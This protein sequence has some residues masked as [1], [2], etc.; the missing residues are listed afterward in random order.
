MIKLVKTFFEKQN[1]IKKC[2]ELCLTSEQKYAKLIELGRTL[3][4]FNPQYKTPEAIVSGCQSVV[5]LHASI[6]EGHVF[7]QAE[8]E[9]LIS[10]GLAYL[11]IYVYSGETPETILKNPPLFIDEIGIS[12]SLTPGRSN[13][14][15]SIYLRMKQEALK[16]YAYN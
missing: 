15:A 1:Y 12:S 10:S 8:S 4:P 13:G 16:L 3:P 5:Y 9:A 11:L 7:F 14:L 6:Q 2:F